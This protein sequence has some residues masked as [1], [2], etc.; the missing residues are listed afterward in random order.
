MKGETSELVRVLLARRGVTAEEDVAAFL[1][2]DYERGLHDPFLLAG[3]ER[4]VARVLAAIAQGERIAVYAD[5]DCDGLPGAALMGDFF[6]KIGYENVETYI[7]HRDREGYG[8]HIEAIDALASRGVSVIITVDVGTVAFDAVAHAQGKGVDVIVTDHHDVIGGVPPAAH[9]VI[10]PKIVPYPFPGLCGTGVAF[11]LVQALLIEGKLRD[12]PAFTGIP[13]GWE[14]WLLDLV[15]IATVADMVPMIGE[16]RALVYWGLRVLRKSPRIGI[17]A[18]CAQVRLRQEEITE[19]DIGFSIAPRINAASRMDEPELALR[20]LTTAD[21]AEADALALH[22]EELNASRKGV[23]AGIVKSAR[24]HVSARYGADDRVVFLGDTA[25]KPALLGLA[26]NSIMNDRG[27]VV[28]LWG[29][30]ARGRLKGSCR[31]DGAVNLADLFA[32]AGEVFEE[33]GGHAASGGFS[34]SPE[35]VHEVAEALARAAAELG[36]EV[37]AEAG[38]AHDALVSL[39]EIS[40][41]LLADVSRLAP[42][43]IGNQKPVFLISR[44]RVSAVRSFG[45]EKNHIE[46]QLAADGMNHSLRAFDFFR[47]PESFSHVPIEGSSAN[48]LATIE[49]D[50]FRGPARLALRL[51]DVLP[52]A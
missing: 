2:P 34:V 13:D 49:R 20:L 10:N 44:V 11:K 19:D 4:A 24:K 31:S 45:K 14:K 7:P 29:R 47:T 50:A 16:N 40:W 22:L 5:Y 52:S 39:R 33:C 36:G 18:L 17:R 32:Q 12:L 21:M 38:S 41:P 51:V 23:V 25:W 26:A 37:R 35:K 46:L 43:G 28:C 3:M 27:G 8:F 6:R 48:I 9:A 30:D 15:A 42:F 1:T